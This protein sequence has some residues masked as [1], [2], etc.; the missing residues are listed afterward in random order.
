MKPNSRKSCAGNMER[1]GHASRG[2]RSRE[3]QIWVG[4]IARCHNE[5]H[6]S[7]RDYGGRGITVGA[8]WLDSFVLFLADM[9]KCP[10]PGHT[11]DR[12]NNNLGYFKKNCRWVTQR[13]QGRNRRDNVFLTANSETLVLTEWAERLG[14]SEN[15]LR[16]RKAKGW[17]DAEIVG[18][19]VKQRLSAT[20]VLKI[21]GDVTSGKLSLTA[22]AKKYNLPFSTVQAIASGRNWSS[23]TRSSHGRKIGR[24]A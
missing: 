9:G 8:R 3:Y 1:H 2:H 10:S 24:A 6:T 22:I 19:P 13:V 23:I 17:S 4:M 20:A 12:R 5:K 21:H 18:V 15:A 14:V 16:L 11:L 7:Y